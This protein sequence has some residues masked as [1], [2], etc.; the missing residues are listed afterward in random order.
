METAT[1][2]APSTEAAAPAAHTPAPA[3]Q[4][5]KSAVEEAKTNPTYDEPTESRR[6]AREA[7]KVEDVRQE[8]AKEEPK[9][10]KAEK[11][12][13]EKNPWDKLDDLKVEPKKEEPVKEKPAGD[14]PEGKVIAELKKEKA[15]AIAE[16]E[17]L[18]TSGGLTEA[19]KSELVTLK[20]EAAEL[21][22]LHAVESLVNDPEYQ[23]HIARPYA[24]QEQIRDQVAEFTSLPKDKIQEA[25]EEPNLLKRGKIIRD[26]LE[27]SSLADEKSLEAAANAL[28]G[29]AKEMHSL[30]EKD[31][32]VREQA[33]NIQ[34]TARSEFQK[35]QS[36]LH[37]EA[38]KKDA[39]EYS[40]AESTV[41]DILSSKVPK[42]LELIIKD[43]NGDEISGLKAMKSAKPATTATG[44]AYQA[45]GSELFAHAVQH[46]KALEA[47]IEGMKSK[48]EARR[49]AKPK[50]P[51]GDE[52]ETQPVQTRSR[53]PIKDALAA[54]KR[55]GFRA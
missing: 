36:K 2:P 21:R 19:E 5:I 14:T 13:A 10:E 8:A 32:N 49:Q 35:K 46:I 7:P 20:S 55:A 11:P 9:P 23:K 41:D 47:E 31:A 24:K 22:K 53:T 3:R 25:L 33:E 15:A 1:A 34:K 4:S 37:E 42:L 43:S 52:T 50:A 51:G 29:V 27:T 16:L 12:D 26:L 30:W 48:E 28:D 44:R 45:K 39:E 6:S 18:K 40:K 38:A 54:D 17:K